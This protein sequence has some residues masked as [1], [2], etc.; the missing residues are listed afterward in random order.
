MLHRTLSHPNVAKLY[1][2]FVGESKSALLYAYC[3]RGSL[4]EVLDNSDLQLDWVF[5]LSF[6]L[7]AAEGMAYLHNRKIVHGRLTTSSCII[8]EQWTLQIKGW[9]EHGIGPWNS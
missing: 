9:L 5:S 2:C 6:G 8:N 7:D 3:S 1:G 4:E